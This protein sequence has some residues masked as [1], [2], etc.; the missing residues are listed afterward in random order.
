MHRGS[1]ESAAPSVNPSGV[2]L[3]GG[4]GDVGEGQGLLGAAAVTNQEAHR[5]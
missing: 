3:E 5:S 1:R 2:T 4:K